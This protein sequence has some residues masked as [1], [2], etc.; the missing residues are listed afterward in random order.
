MRDRSRDPS[1]KLHDVWLGVAPTPRLSY[2]KS[3]RRFIKQMI[4]Y[5]FTER[6]LYHLVL[7]VGGW[8][9]KKL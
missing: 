1:Y 4:F 3:F 8:L 6:N 9:V 2:K 5:R 7:V